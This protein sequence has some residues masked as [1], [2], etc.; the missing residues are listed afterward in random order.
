MPIR[1]SWLNTP[2][3]SQ[4]PNQVSTPT[5]LLSGCL[6]PKSSTPFNTLLAVVGPPVAVSS[7]STKSS[8]VVPQPDMRLSTVET[9]SKAKPQAPL[10]DL[11]LEQSRSQLLSLL[12]KSLSMFYQ[13]TSPLTRRFPAASSPAS[14][15]A[16]TW[17]NLRLSN[18][19]L[20]LVNACEIFGFSV[21][22]SVG[23]STVQRFRLGLE[24]FRV[25]VFCAH[26]YI[27]KCFFRFF[28]ILCNIVRPF[29]QCLHH[30]E[31]MTRLYICVTDVPEALP[32][33]KSQLH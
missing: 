9:T 25:R 23:C 4:A 5:C 7:M 18:K 20:A 6:T 15:T 22:Q 16:R 13:Q 27:P 32:R 31:W 10:T 14:S 19:R 26:G 1:S 12:V 28:N 17:K 3:L 33:P 2:C 29:F 24:F 11:P 21:V 30:F 8:K